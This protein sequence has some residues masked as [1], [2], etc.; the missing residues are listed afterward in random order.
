MATTPVC[1]NVT[2]PAEVDEVTENHDGY[3]PLR[4]VPEPDLLA[5]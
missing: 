2:M 5:A 3:R 4:V 1:G